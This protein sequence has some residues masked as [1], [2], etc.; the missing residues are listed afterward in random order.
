SGRVAVAAKEMVVTALS[1]MSRVSSAFRYVDYEVDIARQ[2]TVQNLTTKTGKPFGRFTIEDLCGSY[3]FTLF[4][5]EW[6]QFRYHCMAQS[7]VLIRCKIEQSTYREG[8][9]INISQIKPLSDVLE[10]D[11]HTLTIKLPIEEVRQDFVEEL[12]AVIGSSKGGV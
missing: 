10:K 8:C 11:I 12:S 4:S 1:Q 2:D 6:E 9:E 5:R 7:T 3:T